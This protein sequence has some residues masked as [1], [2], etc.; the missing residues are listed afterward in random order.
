MTPM[1]R[2]LLI[3]SFFGRH[4]CIHQRVPVTVTLIVLGTVCVGL[5]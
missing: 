5:T 1:R 4:G 3:I 2:L